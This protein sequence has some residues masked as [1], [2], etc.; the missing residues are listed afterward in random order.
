MTDKSSSPSAT[1]S[2]GNEALKA[3]AEIAD[4]MDLPLSQSATVAQVK[5]RVLERLSARS[6][7]AQNA[8]MVPRSRYDACNRDWLEEKDARKKLL[9]KATAELSAIQEGL[10]LCLLARSQFEG[11]AM[12]A[13]EEIEHRV[14]G[15]LE[16]MGNASVPS[17]TPL[18][19][20]FG[21]VY[22]TRDGKFHFAQKEEI[23]PFDLHESR[24]I[25]VKEGE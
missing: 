25:Y 13:L 8:D 9:A 14:R 10:G 20:E 7:T 21:N 1:L 17:A 23:E 12:G 2:E 24:T 5:S 16:N 4:A 15:M 19:R 22:R 18:F 3:L 6:E 11:D